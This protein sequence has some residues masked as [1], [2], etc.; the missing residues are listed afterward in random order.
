MNGKEKHKIRQYLTFTL[1]RELF[2]LEISRVCEV[3]DCVRITEVPSLPGYLCGVINLRGSVISVID[4]R[5]MFGMNKLEKTVDTCIIIVEVENGTLRMGAL[6]DSVR[7]V[8]QLDPGR[9][10]PP[11]E[12]GTKLDTAFIRGIGRVNDNFMI[13]LD[14]EQVLASVE[15]ELLGKSDEAG[16]EDI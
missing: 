15:A 2:A 7:E 6:A 11:P 10:E 8:V 14:I 16:S 3:V 4:L 1:D 9:I 13:I 5:L 12:F